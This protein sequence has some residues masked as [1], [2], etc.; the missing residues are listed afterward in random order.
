MVVKANPPPLAIADKEG[1]RRIG[2]PPEMDLLVVSTNKAKINTQPRSCNCAPV[3]SG[4]KA[5]YLMLLIQPTA[6]MT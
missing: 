2:V 5:I 3:P 1:P 4:A 6:W